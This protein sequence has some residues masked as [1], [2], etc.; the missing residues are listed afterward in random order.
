M[1]NE[2]QKKNQEK[3]LLRKPKVQAEWK[4]KPKHAIKQGK[5]AGGAEVGLGAMKTTLERVYDK[6]K[7]REALDSLKAQ[8]RRDVQAKNR[9]SKNISKVV[10]SKLLRKR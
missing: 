2:A 9:L 10:M 1:R 4:K 3:V 5:S 6:E 7:K 8:V